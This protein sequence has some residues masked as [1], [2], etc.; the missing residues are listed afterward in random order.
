MFGFVNVA[1][2]RSFCFRGEG[3][4]N[5]VISA[6]SK[7]SG[8]RIVWRLAKHRKSGHISIKPKCHITNAY[9]ENLIAPL[10]PSEF[11]I[12]PKIVFLPIQHVHHL[13]KLPWLRCN[14]KIESFEE[15]TVANAVGWRSALPGTDVEIAMQENIRCVAALQMPDATC[16]PQR[17]ELS[18][19]LGPTITVELKPKQGFFQMHEGVD[20]P[21]CNNCVMQIQKVN[22]AGTFSAMY[23]FCP[24]DLYSGNETRMRAA[25]QSLMLNPHRN[26]R[27]FIDGDTVHS[28]EDPKSRAIL[29][30]LL[31]PD[32]SGN[33]D[34]LSDALCRILLAASDP[35]DTMPSN[36]VPL[37]S[38][39]GYLLKAQRLDPLGIVAAHEIFQ[40]LTYAEQRRL[41]DKTRLLYPRSDAE[42]FLNP[43]K[44]DPMALLERYLFAATL[45]DC[46]LMITLC[47]VPNTESGPNTVKVP[48]PVSPNVE[49]NFAYS[50]KVV[51]LDPKT[52]KNLVNGYTRY[53]EG[54]Q[55]IRNNPHIHRPCVPPSITS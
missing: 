50:V 24:L 5:Y 41:H 3:G 35:S 25:L 54:V 11:L 22:S 9:M 36:S 2:Y 47:Q 6:R 1:D 33:V 32:H 40:N 20:V 23:D 16:I 34:T 44:Q 14:Q 18:D 43:N 29:D 49:L 27:V 19:A 52:P 31:F 8:E 10:V 46:S 15:L 17:G 21:F 55:I 13:A 26:L 42:S 51:D 38:V 12:K 7:K 4:A 30:E 37:S 53:M 28:D 45:K 39:L 48:S